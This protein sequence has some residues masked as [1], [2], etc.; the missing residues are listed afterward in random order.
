M[1]AATNTRSDLKDCIFIA[2]RLEVATTWVMLVVEFLRM[3]TSDLSRELLARVADI[4]TYICSLTGQL[5]E[6]A[7]Q[8]ESGLSLEVHSR[9]ELRR[10]AR[11]P[12]SR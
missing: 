7:S 5:K 4:Q 9:C 12:T 1:P 6:A 8:L 2:I 3:Y 11:W 10:P